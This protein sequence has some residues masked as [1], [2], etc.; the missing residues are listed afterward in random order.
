[1]WPLVT[2]RKQLDA[3][4]MMPCLAAFFQVENLCVTMCKL[5]LNWESVCHIE[6]C[7]N[8]TPTI[9][10]NAILLWCNLCFA[11]VLY[12]LIIFN[13]TH[14]IDLKFS[15]WK[16]IALIWWWLV[17][18]LQIQK[19]RI[20]M[21]K[22]N[23]T[24]KKMQKKQKMRTKSEMESKKCKEKMLGQNISSHTFLWLGILCVRQYY[25]LFP[26]ICS[27]VQCTCIDTSFCMNKWKVQKQKQAI[28]AARRMMK[29]RCRSY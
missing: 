25:F 28:W 21:Q 7:M 2:V 29:I 4:F 27:C 16:Y 8:C 14:Q 24:N 6:R 9:M 18:F 13:S 11:L 12:L 1:M 15:S 17:H 3:I 10:A 19:K 5:S 23:N 22:Q 26:Y 20:P